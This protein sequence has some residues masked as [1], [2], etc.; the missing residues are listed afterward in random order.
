M[1]TSALEALE[2]AWERLWQ[3]DTRATPFQSPAWLIPWTRYLWGGGELIL[4]QE[5]SGQNL[6]GFLPLFRWGTERTQLSFLGAGVSDYGDYLGSFPHFLL[7]ADA[8]L[9]EVRPG[10]PLLA[11]GEAVPCSVCPVLDLAH[12]PATLDPKLKADL[13]RARNKLAGRPHRFTLDA[14]LQ[15]FFHLYQLR[16]GA[17]SNPKLNPFQTEVA[18]RFNE[19]G[20]LRLHVLHIDSEPAAAIFGIAAHRVLYFYLS[21]FDAR[22]TR[23]SPGALLLAHAIE[24]AKAEG[25]THA[26]FLRGAEPYK[27]L[28]GAENR[29]NY[30][31][32]TGRPE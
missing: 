24:C 32:S 11:A 8:V 15:A 29:I 14:D 6:T 5:Y 4:N 18:Q 1:N 10:S 27:Y 21:A 3:K 19:R 28:W 16:W 17:P 30:T 23:L 12:Y 2:P 25:A 22:F 31:V 26:D 7:P 9:E 13:R 20:M